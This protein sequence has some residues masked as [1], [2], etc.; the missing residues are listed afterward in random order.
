MLMPDHSMLAAQSPE[1]GCVTLTVI[2]PGAGSTVCKT[3]PSKSSGWFSA[4]VAELG[5]VEA[6]PF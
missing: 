6:S 4:G 3:S 1:L 5:A 2:R